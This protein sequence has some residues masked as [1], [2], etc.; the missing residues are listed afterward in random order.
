MILCADSQG[1]LDM[2]VC[3][4]A[5]DLAKNINAILLALYVIDVDI[6]RYGQI[7]HLAPAGAMFDFC[8]YVKKQTDDDAR[9]MFLPLIQQAQGIALTTV[10]HIVSKGRSKKEFLKLCHKKYPALHI[11]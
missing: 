4:D 11:L 2:Q 10:L 3:K 1:V 5:V 7:D 9:H 8:D 6:E